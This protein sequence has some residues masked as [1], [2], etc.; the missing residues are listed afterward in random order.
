VLTFSFHFQEE[1]WSQ[2]HLYLKSADIYE[3]ESSPILTVKEMKGCHAHP[4]HTIV[5]VVGRAIAQA[6][7]R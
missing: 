1:Q 2:K 5:A 4:A 3:S 7:S 6:V